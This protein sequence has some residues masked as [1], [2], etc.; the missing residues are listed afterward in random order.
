VTVELSNGM[1]VTV[2]DAGEWREH[3]VINVR[4]RERD[5]LNGAPSAPDVPRYDMGGEYELE[6]PDARV[7]G[8]RCDARD[9]DPG[10]PDF[11]GE[12]T[13]TITVTHRH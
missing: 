5:L 10:S 8:E 13:A 11:P 3:P 6:L 9:A 2:Y 4:Q 1:T 7:I 12:G